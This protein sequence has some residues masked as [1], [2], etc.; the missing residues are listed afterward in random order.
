MTGAQIAARATR[1]AVI[2]RASGRDRAFSRFFRALMYGAVG[3]SM[4]ALATL[5]YDVA[6]DGIPKLS[7]DFLTSFPSRIITR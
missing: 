1:R 7:W 2:P 3:L 5:L 6:R 4:L